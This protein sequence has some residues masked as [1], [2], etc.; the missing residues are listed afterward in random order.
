MSIVGTPRILISRL[1]AM[2]DCILTT[3]V[4]CALRDHFPRA[5]LTWVVESASA[6]LLRGHRCLDH[7]IVLRKGWLKSPRQIMRLRRQLREL[8]IDVTVDPQGLFRSGVVARLSGAPRRI[9]LAP[10]LGRELTPWMSTELVTPRSSHVVDR[11]LELLEPLGVH[12]PSVRFGLPEDDSASARMDDYL[13]QNRLRQFAVVNPAAN[14]DSRLWVMERFGQVAQHLADRGVA[15]VVC[16][17]GARE[18]GLAE[19]IVRASAGTARL[20]P[21]TTLPELAAV[22]RRAQMYVGSDTGPMHMAVA[23]GTTCVGL[24]GPTEPRISGPYG[25]GHVAIQAYYHAGTSRER[26]AASNDAMRAIDVEMVCRGVDRALAGPSTSTSTAR[27][28]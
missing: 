27:A 19:E 5:S 16:W 15:S 12:R 25:A 21:K 14:W 28:A 9:G 7:L 18:R 22:L 1:S 26:R 11:S 6:P 17:A 3:P 20:L 13:R 10:P 24:F 8:Q 23:V 4:L 2:G